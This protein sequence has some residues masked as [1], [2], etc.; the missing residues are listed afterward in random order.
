MTVQDSPPELLSLA[1]SNLQ[2]LTYTQACH[3]A[4]TEVTLVGLLS[5]LTR[6]ELRIHSWW[7]DCQPLRSLGLV[8]LV[9]GHC[10]ELE[11]SLFVPGALTKLQRLHIEESEWLHSY[12]RGSTQ[13]QQ[14]QGRIADAIFSLPDLQQ[15]SGK[16]SILDAAQ[17]DHLVTWQRAQTVRHAMIE[18]S[19]L[20]AA[21][22]SCWRK[23]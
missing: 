10:P 9:I 15:V 13:R 11:H 8:E 6:L 17:H 3:L 16:S 5:H 1:P 14:V 21:E 4:Q 18:Y 22:M 12:F 7:G 19:L 20:K 23:P 2:S